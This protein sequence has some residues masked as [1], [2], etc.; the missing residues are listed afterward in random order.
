MTPPNSP[1]SSPELTERLMRI[2]TALEI[3]RKRLSSSGFHEHAE[4]MFDALR[5]VAALEALSSKNELPSEIAER[6]DA[7]IAEHRAHLAEMH[8]QY[9]RGTVP[10]ERCIGIVLNFGDLLDLRAALNPKDTDQ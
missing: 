2:G 1:N 5:D 7:R 4:Q 6:V 9:G 8:K 3:A 10:D